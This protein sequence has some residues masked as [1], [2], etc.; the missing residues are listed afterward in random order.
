MT[1]S[2]KILNYENYTT[3]NMIKENSISIYK[4]TLFT[5]I[6]DSRKD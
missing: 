5:S 4:I 6:A 2:L 3:N 1:D